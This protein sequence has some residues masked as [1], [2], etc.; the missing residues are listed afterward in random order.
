MTALLSG[1]T[2]DSLENEIIDCKSS[3]EFN[4]VVDKY[5]AKVSFN[6]V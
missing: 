5:S 4:V 6:K 2:I 3:E 1:I